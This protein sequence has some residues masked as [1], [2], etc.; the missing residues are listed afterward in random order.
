M[1]FILECSDD[2]YSMSIFSGG[3]SCVVN[4]L[5]ASNNHRRRK[6]EELEDE[7]REYFRK[8]NEKED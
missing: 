7:M 3:I 8:Q 2:I 5:I 6:R 1:K 4:L